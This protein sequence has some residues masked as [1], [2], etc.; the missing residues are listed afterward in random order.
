MATNRR[1]VPR[2]WWKWLVV[3]A[4]IAIGGYVWFGMGGDGGSSNEPTGGGELAAITPTPPKTP[5]P[6]PAATTPAPAEPAEPAD[7]EAESPPEDATV[8]LSSIE[9]RPPVETVAVDQQTVQAEETVVAEDDTADI[10]PPAPAPRRSA[11]DRARTAASASSASQRFQQGM[12]L[13]TQEDYIEGRRVLSR[14]LFSE[15]HL[16]GPGDAQSI[17]DVLMSV[18]RDMIFSPQVT[19]GDPIVQSYEVQPGDLL[20]KIAPSFSVTYQ[21]IERVNGI[22]ARRL[23]AGKPIKLVRGP[24]HARVIKHEYVMDLFVRGDDG[25]PLF[26]WSF[27]VGLGAEDSTPVGVWRVGVGKVVNPQWTNPRTG[28]LYT[29]DDPA[30]PI[31]E[32]WVPLEGATDQTSTLSGYGIHGTIEPE[33]VGSQHSMGCIRMLPDDVELVYEMLVPEASTVEIVP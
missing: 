20:A 32:R 9:L 6:E 3:V 27:P 17:R 2:W 21:F 13:I 29:A 14:V 8:E 23:Q 7:A 5:Q 15:P 24:F 26:V 25:A 18:N 12:E 31:G 16:L 4:V 11:V 1:A 19:T 28:E 33:S 22:D 10:E 30:N